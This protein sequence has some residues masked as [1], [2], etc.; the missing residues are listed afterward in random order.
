M[1]R[2]IRAMGVELEGAWDEAP[3]FP[4]VRD[5]SVEAQGAYKGECQSPPYRDWHKLASFIVD[6][7][8]DHIDGS[9]GLHVHFSFPNAGLY[10]RLMDTPFQQYFYKF[11]D[12]WAA[13]HKP[14]RWFNGRILGQ[15]RFCSREWLPD[16]QAA[17][18]DKYTTPRYTAWNFCHGLH[19]TAECRLLPMFAQPEKSIA[20]I[21]AVK[22]SVM[23]YLRQKNDEPAMLA[24]ADMDEVE[25]EL[26]SELK[27]NETT[28]TICV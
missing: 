26:D 2:F 11:M 15:N 16:V 20:A 14:G 6:N 3:H 8:P 18:G 24:D 25:A 17:S 9:C 23:L 28:E 1:N 21:Q 13:K 5:S 10:S 27:P 22:M 7:H 12:K 4:L 19:G